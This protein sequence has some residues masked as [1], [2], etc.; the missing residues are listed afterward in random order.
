MSQEMREKIIQ[1]I[2]DEY[3][4]DSSTEITEETPL[5][6]SG[7]VDSFSMVSLKMFLEHEYGINIPDNEA[8]TERFET[9]SSIMQLVSS[10]L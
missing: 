9:V 4:D 1:Y 10:K 6:T 8:A 3:L 2:K 5:I 7:L